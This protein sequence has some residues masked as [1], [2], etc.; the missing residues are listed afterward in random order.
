MRN[1]NMK[2]GNEKENPEIFK[3]LPAN[4]EHKTGHL[5]TLF[6]PHTNANTFY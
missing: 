3:T 2:K 4:S 1:T 5:F 6:K